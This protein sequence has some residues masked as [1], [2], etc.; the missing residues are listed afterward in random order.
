MRKSLLLIISGIFILAVFLL[1]VSFASNNI[2]VSPEKLEEDIRYS[3]QIDESWAVTGSVSDSMA[4]YISYPDDKS[5]HTFSVYLKRS[6]LSYGYFF[7]A[8]GSIGEIDDSIKEFTFEGC[9]ELALVSMNTQKIAR[10]EID[11][12]I[13]IKAVELD[14]EKPFAVVLDK[15]AGELRFYDAEGKAVEYQ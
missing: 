8:G 7:R 6:G 4:A 2:G 10:L 13:E 15:N 9:N 3:Q 1:S 5:D 11:N 12:G 14:S